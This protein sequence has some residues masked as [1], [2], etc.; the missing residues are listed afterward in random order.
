MS[1]DVGFQDVVKCFGPV[2]VLHGVSFE[3]APGRVYGLLGETFLTRTTQEWLDTLEALHIP[4]ARLRSTD[5]LFENEH[6]NAVGFFEEIETAQGP[7]R[8][9]GVPVWFSATPGHV[10]GAAP[11]LGEDNL[12][13]LSELDK[14][15]EAIAADADDLK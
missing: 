15:A 13:V 5:E 3:L 10:R 2:E 8:F 6:L 7:V 14:N 11:M 9:P 12:R 4:C 1:L